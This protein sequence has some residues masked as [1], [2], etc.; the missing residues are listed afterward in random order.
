MMIKITGLNT[1]E[2]IINLWIYFKVFLNNP[3]ASGDTFP[4]VCSD[5]Q[6]KKIKTNVYEELKSY[7]V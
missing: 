6:K 3:C 2:L 5:K 7:I 1:T 4:L